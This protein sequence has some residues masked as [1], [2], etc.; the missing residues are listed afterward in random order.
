M[1]PL[2]QKLKID[3]SD[4]KRLSVMVLILSN[5]VP[6]F[7]VIFMGWRVFPVIALFWF[8]NVVIGAFN[9]L[10]M[11]L[12]VSGKSRQW[13]AKAAMI[14]FFCVHYGLFTLVHGAF[15]FVIFGALIE[16]D[17]L[18]VGLANAFNTLLSSQLGWAA[19]ALMVSHTVSFV[20]RLPGQGRIQEK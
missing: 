11:A 6:V 3:G 13:G 7:G 4:L 16:Q 2:L 1:G 5:L 20:V 17:D 14:P 12:S 8:E 9:V 19:L 18:P 10:K 15:V